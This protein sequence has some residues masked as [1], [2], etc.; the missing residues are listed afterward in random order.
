MPAPNFALA[1][2]SPSAITLTTPDWIVLGCYGALLVL[3]GIYFSRRGAK[4]VRDYFLAERSMPAW[5]VAFSILATAQSAATFIG[6]PE[7]SY[8]G[9]LTYLAASLG[10]LIAALLVSAFFLP[11]YYRAGVASPYELLENRFGPGARTA[12]S[13][14]YLLGRLLGSGARTYI[15]ALPLSLAVYGDATLPHVLVSIG[16]IMLVGTVYTL[17]GGVRSVIWTDV[18]QVC[19]YLGAGVAALAFL[20]SIV[21]AP[22]D[23]V[24]DALRTAGPDG[25][26][27]LRVV[28]PGI[29]FAPEVTIARG[30]PYSILASITGLMLLN[31][32]VMAIDQDLVQRCLTCRD[33]LHAAR[34]VIISQLLGVPVVLL[35]L[36]IGLLLFVYYQR[37]DLM[38]VSAPAASAPASKDIFQTFILSR[39][40]PG[41]RGLM[42]AGVLAI[43]PI[44]INATLNSMAST[45]MNDTVLRVRGSSGPA[46]D[47]RASRLLVVAC[48]VT[49]AGVACLCAWWQQHSKL[50]LLDFAQAVLAFAYTGLLGVFLCA[51]F[52]RRGSTRSAITAMLAAAGL[53]VL[54]QPFVLANL[55]RFVSSLPSPFAYADAALAWAGAWA[56]SWHFVAGTAVAFAI[57]LAGSTPP[58]RRR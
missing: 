1:Q 26:D 57:C 31:L 29:R 52:T 34:S 22:L 45:L 12:T 48:G 33:H 20:L 24:L 37:P 30:A 51:L 17:A 8:V 47:L 49:L 14:A 50:P 10:P 16:A 46:S 38:G 55:R 7:R 11:R 42:I 43:G 4:G 39:M 40:P 5:A 15:G 19:V 58:G 56:F 35:F 36:A 3:T 32:A 23:A 54:V 27:K 53:C 6:V 41:L 13:W 21:P 2:A 44:G 25:A 18:L 9:D 28:D